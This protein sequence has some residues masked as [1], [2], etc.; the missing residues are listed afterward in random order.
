MYCQFEEFIVACLFH[1][2]TVWRSNPYEYLIHNTSPQKICLFHGILNLCHAPLLVMQALGIE[3]WPAGEAGGR[4]AKQAAAGEAGGWPAKQVGG[5][6]SMQEA[7][8][9]GGRPAKH[10]GG[11]RSRRAA[12]E[13]A[14]RPAK[15]AG[16]QRSRR[17]AGKAGGQLAKQAR[18]R[19]SRQIRWETVVRWAATARR[20]AGE[21]DSQWG[22]HL[23]AYRTAVSC[24]FS[25]STSYW[26]SSWL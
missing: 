14:G 23:S 20:A 3:R 8:K 1:D 6:R 24:L 10:A 2:S 9:A 12:R 25:S 26:R 7:G 18:G 19:R 16:G 4:P 22:G 5:R 13:A 11:R 15:Q 21:A 17:D